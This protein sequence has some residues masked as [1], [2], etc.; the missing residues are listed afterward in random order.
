MLGLAEGRPPPGFDEAA[1]QA[2]LAGLL[3]TY[4]HL[5]LK[6]LRLGPPLP[7]THEISVRPHVRLP[8][9]L[10][11]IGKAFGQMQLAAA[12]LDPALDPF[13]VAGSFYLR[14]LARH[15]GPVGKP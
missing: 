5:S 2:E 3:A 9:S 6:E 1:F 4:R 11:L 15:D 12:E 7:Q 10:A 8:S 13:S 14:E